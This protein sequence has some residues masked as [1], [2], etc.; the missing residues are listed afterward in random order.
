MLAHQVVPALGVVGTLSPALYSE[1]DFVAHIAAVRVQQLDDGQRDLCWQLLL[2]LPTSARLKEVVCKPE[3]VG[4][5]LAVQTAKV[6]LAEAGSLGLHCALQTD[7]L[8]F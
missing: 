2:L 1:A 5:A 4:A 6:A 8:R 3:E 7:P